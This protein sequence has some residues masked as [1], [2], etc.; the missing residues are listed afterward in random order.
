MAK[1][2]TT[3]RTEQIEQSKSSKR[4]E[5][6]RRSPRQISRRSTNTIVDLAVTHAKVVNTTTDAESSRAAALAQ[7]KKRE[8]EAD[9]RVR[10]RLKLRRKKREREETTKLSHQIKTWQ[11][12]PVEGSSEGGSKGTQK[13]MI[14]IKR[15]KGEGRKRSEAADGSS[16]TDKKKEIVEGV[17]RDL[18]SRIKSPKRLAKAFAKLD[19]DSSHALSQA[20][21]ARLIFTV[22]ERP[23]TKQELLRQ[24]GIVWKDAGHMRK[25]GGT[26]ELDLAT[27]QAWLFSTE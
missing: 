1:I 13:K 11:V 21:F 2:T 22:M 7:I 9:A 24:V 5:R 10:K 18:A 17:R 3:P 16:S 8:I 19:T 12:A 23:E 26:T 14:N 6:S 27:L 15:E 4:K 20:E 25:S